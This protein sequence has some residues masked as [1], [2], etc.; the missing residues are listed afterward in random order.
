MRRACRARARLAQPPA[1]TDLQH[2]RHELDLADPA[3][4]ELDVAVLEL[5]RGEPP[6]ALALVP[7][8][9]RDR[10]R[11]ERLAP[12]EGPGLAQQ[13]ASD[14]AVARERPRLEQSEALPGSAAP[15]VVLGG[16]LQRVGDRAGPPLGAQPQVDA[17]DMALFGG[18]REHRRELAAERLC[19]RVRA[20]LGAGV[21][22]HVDEVDVG[23]E[24]ELAASELA[25]RQHGEPRRARRGRA[26]R[27]RLAELARGHLERGL[28][29]P[30]G[31]R[32]QR[33]ER[34]ADRRQPQQVTDRDP[35]H[36]APAQQPQRVARGCGRAA[37]DQAPGLGGDRSRAGRAR[38]HA[39]ARQPLG[40]LGMADHLLGE[41]RASAEGPEQR[42]ARPGAALEQLSQRECLVL[43]R[44]ALEPDERAE[45]VGQPRERAQQRAHALLEG[46]AQPR[47]GG[48]ESQLAC[49][50]LRLVEA[51]A[52]QPGESCLARRVLEQARGRRH[53]HDCPLFRRWSV[54]GGGRGRVSCARCKLGANERA[55]R[56]LPHERRAGVPVAPER[57][58][59]RRFRAACRPTSRSCS[60]RTTPCGRSSR[61]SA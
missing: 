2:L 24:V 35:Q 16:G 32:R 29:E 39:R 15:A 58:R 14:G 30:V 55:R 3:A 11:S 44:E 34:P 45:R 31:E 56:R 8:H 33:R 54:A 1:R 27:G 37:R 51:T 47:V 57:G 42:L 43:A 21:P 23:A 48:D 4:A 7:Q 20:R 17:I 41:E 10:V 25:E 52:P 9:L 6:V 59:A 28:D 61:S 40:P 22:V 13:L 36:L 53:A 49:R 19:A 5:P 50:P 46:R 12:D 18:V 38:Q 26:P 60:R